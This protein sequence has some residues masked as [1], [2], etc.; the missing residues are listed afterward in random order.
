MQSPPCKA[1]Y[2]GPRTSCLCLLNTRLSCAD[3]TRN[4]YLRNIPLAFL[5]C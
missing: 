5:S 2:V 1:V 4:V 3:P